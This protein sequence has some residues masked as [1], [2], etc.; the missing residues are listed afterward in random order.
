VILPLLWS[1]MVIF[2]HF[3]DLCELLNTMG[4]DILTLLTLSIHG[5]R[6]QL[7]PF[8]HFYC[9]RAHM[10][11]RL[12]DVGPLAWPGSP[13]RRG[14]RAHER[15]GPQQCGYRASGWRDHRARGRRDRRAQ[16]KPH[17]NQRP[18]KLTSNSV[19]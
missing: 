9:I 11:H 19:L 2:P 16:A 7:P 18:I 14:P 10:N 15:H 13:G 1:L 5:T 12:A 4:I 3:F 17:G 6:C 8:T